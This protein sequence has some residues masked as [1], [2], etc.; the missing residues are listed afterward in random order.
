VFVAKR[1]TKNVG[2]FIL[3][4]GLLRMLNTFPILFS[5]GRHL[6]R[7]IKKRFIL[8]IPYGLCSNLR[9]CRKPNA[10]ITIT[11]FRDK[12]ILKMTLI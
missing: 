8:C 7:L 1:K 10:F 11:V 3:V 4:V 2:G 6:L 5:F 9:C 12:R